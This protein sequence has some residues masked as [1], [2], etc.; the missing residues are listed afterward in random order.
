MLTKSINIA[1]ETHIF[2]PLPQIFVLANISYMSDIKNKRYRQ[3]YQSARKQHVR[4]FF[5]NCALTF[6]LAHVDYYGFVNT[7][8]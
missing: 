6:V 2:W 4:F 7:V 3:M 1:I 5:S 8:V